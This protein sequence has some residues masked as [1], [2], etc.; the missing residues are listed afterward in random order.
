MVELEIVN[1]SVSESDG[2]VT[3]IVRLSRAFSEDIQFLISTIDGS[4]TGT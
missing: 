2:Q 1:P 3:A 4:A